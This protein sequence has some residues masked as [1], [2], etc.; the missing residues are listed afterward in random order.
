[1]CFI[2]IFKTLKMCIIDVLSAIVLSRQIIG[3]Q[4]VRGIKT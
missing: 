4:D 3:S 1:M 2:E